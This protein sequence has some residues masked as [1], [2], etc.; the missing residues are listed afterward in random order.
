MKQT[1]FP[2][3]LVLLA[4]C[5]TIPQSPPREDGIARLG[6]ST[7]VDG[8]LVTPLR[9]VEDSRCPINARCV[10]AGRVILH[11]RVAGH[12]A[13]DLALG[14]S[15]QVADGALTLVSVTPD[16]I[17]GEGPEIDPADYRFTFAFEGGF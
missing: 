5:A 3:L 6:E 13:L 16:Q 2:A 10:W 17:A 8:P 9:V 12:Q 4:S 11:V 1:I 7:Y 14:E 15:Q